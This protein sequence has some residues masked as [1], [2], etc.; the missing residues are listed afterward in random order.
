MERREPAA[1]AAVALPPAAM[2]F[3]YLARLGI[4]K[5]ILWCYLI[6]YVAIV[7]HYFDPDPSIWLAA[8]GLGALIGFSLVLGVEPSPRRWRRLDPWMVMRLFATPF[9]VS[10]FAALIKGHGFVAVFSP[11]ARENLLAAGAC[12]L[13]LA[14]CWAARRLGAARE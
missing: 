3:R 14:G 9:C 5:Q 6:W 7:A 10:S 2:P 13:F 11:V 8:A 12:A 1:G 4:G